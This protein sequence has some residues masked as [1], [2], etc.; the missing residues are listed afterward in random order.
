M[1]K[2]GTQM[3]AVIRTWQSHAFLVGYGPNYYKGLQGTKYDRCFTNI[4]LRT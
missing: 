1:D 3:T 4:M 2:S